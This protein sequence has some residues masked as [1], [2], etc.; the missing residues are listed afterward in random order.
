MGAKKMLET[1][2]PFESGFSME[3]LDV[4]EPEWT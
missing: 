1:D 2:I 4:P 3:K